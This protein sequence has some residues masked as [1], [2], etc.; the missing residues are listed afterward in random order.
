MMRKTPGR[1]LFVPA[2]FVYW[3]WILR[4]E[5]VTSRGEDRVSTNKNDPNLNA[6]TPELRVNLTYLS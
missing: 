4:Y 5:S 3:H 2:L 1:V 6:L